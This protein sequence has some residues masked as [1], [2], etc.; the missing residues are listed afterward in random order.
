MLSLMKNNNPNKKIFFIVPTLTGGGAE[1]IVATIANQLSITNDVSVITFYDSD[2]EYFLE[3]KINRFSF[4]EKPQKLLFFKT[5]KAFKRISKLRKILKNNPNSTFISFLS[6]C[7]FNLIISSLFLNDKPKIIVSERNNPK[8]KNT[9]HRMLI[10]IL[11]KFSNE[12]V[13]CSKGIQY[14]LKNDFKLDSVVVYNPIRE[15]K[16]LEKQIH[17][18]SNKFS[19]IFDKYEKKFLFVGRLA[20][21]KNIPFMLQSFK[22]YLG[23]YNDNSCLILLGSGPLKNNLVK[24]V[25]DLNIKHRVF[26]LGR[27][28][29]V[30]GFM[31]LSNVLLLTSLWEGMPNVLLESVANNLQ[32]IATDCH[33]GPREILTD[34]KISESI[35][36]PFCG[37][38]GSLVNFDYE[39][40]SQ[41]MKNISIENKIYTINDDFSLQK[42]S[43]CWEK[44]I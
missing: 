14:I 29:Y 27:Q 35:E 21:Q 10:R 44:I 4:S 18:V 38:Y 37:K 24:I 43:K 26:F 41:L 1:R 17:A 16:N 3:N 5:I 25:D 2:D 6:G 19:Y 36:Y 7:N 15:I 23:K 30:D 9:A 33:T 34:L 32:I 31:Q 12:I 13:S 40:L 11:Y 39:I 8:R 28:D 20:R 22:E 42:V